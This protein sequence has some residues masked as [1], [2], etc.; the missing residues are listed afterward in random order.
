M[1]DIGLSE[2]LII[3]AV[4]LIVLGPSKLP[5]V[6]RKLGRGLAEF[7]RTSED[8]RRSILLDDTPKKRPPFTDAFPSAPRN[9]SFEPPSAPPGD[10]PPGASVPGGPPSSAG[11]PPEEPGPSNREEG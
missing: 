8:L 3:L 4:A 7:R 1:L 10:E 2:L 5:E 11:I 9:R 6:A